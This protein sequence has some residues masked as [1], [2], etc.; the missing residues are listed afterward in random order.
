MLGASNQASLLVMLEAKP[1]Q[2][3]SY[4]QQVTNLASHVGD[5]STTSMN[6]VED[7]QPLQVMLGN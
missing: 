6:H 5:S 1:S 7:N 2:H 4:W 3:K